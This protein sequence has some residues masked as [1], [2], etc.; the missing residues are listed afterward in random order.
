MIEESQ[1]KIRSELENFFQH[2]NASES[3][4]FPE[5]GLQSNR[6]CFDSKAFIMLFPSILFI[7]TANIHDN[8]SNLATIK[9]YYSLLL[10]I[11]YLS[12]V[13]ILIQINFGDY[14]HRNY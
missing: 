1:Q 2:Q 7:A 4:W 3:G 11:I 6:N 12:C 5:I 14:F 13:G 10:G 9:Q 8:D